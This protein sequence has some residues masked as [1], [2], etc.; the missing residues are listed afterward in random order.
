MVKAFNENPSP[1]PMLEFMLVA[2]R[3]S[4]LTSQIT[5]VLADWV[6]NFAK[7]QDKFRRQNGYRLR[8]EAAR[9]AC[10]HLEK[11][12]TARKDNDL[13]KSYNSRN[14]EYLRERNGLSRTKRW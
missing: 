4:E 13:A 1:A 3:S 5:K 2:A 12:A 7:D 6:E 14:R 10:I 9:L 11:T 8:L